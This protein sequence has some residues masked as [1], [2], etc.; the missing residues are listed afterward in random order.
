MG[1]GSRRHKTE[2]YVGKIED[3]KAPN[4]VTKYNLFRS[5][6][7]NTSP[8]DIRKEYTST[9]DRWLQENPN[10]TSDEFRK[11][12]GI[13]I[14]QNGNELLTSD[15]SRKRVRQ[16][17]EVAQRPSGAA[18]HGESRQLVKKPFFS[19]FEKLEGHHKKGLANLGVFF[20]GATPKQAFELRQRMLNEDFIGGT[21]RRNWAW[22]TKQQHDLT[23]KIL[24]YASDAEI[25]DPKFK[26]IEFFDLDKPG[27]KGVSGLSDKFKKYIQSV[28]FDRPKVPWGGANQ[29]WTGPI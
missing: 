15:F 27:R 3:V 17:R 16:M 11:K 1:L 18:I 13:V 6:Q 21:D 9:L 5:T 8:E 22:L 19:K 2:L 14:D 20:D 12:Y 28:P 26:G 7:G 10:G 23:H 24:G 29:A 4:W 25:D